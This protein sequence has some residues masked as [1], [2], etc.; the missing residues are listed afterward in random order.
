MLHILPYIQ[1]A[2]STIIASIVEDIF[3]SDANPIGV[4]DYNE[5]NLEGDSI[6]VNAIWNSGF[7]ILIAAVLLII[8]LI[9]P[10]FSP[11]VW[12]SSH[13]ELSITKLITACI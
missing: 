1:A 9:I 6:C 8:D 4:C 10:F 12:L 11:R 2:A 5:G 3:A 13:I 7:S